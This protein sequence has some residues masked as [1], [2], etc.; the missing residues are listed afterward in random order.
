[1]KHDSNG[2]SIHKGVAPILLPEMSIADEKGSL[3]P[4]EKRQGQS[5]PRD[6]H[7]A[8]ESQTLVKNRDMTCGNR[9]E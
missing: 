7:T 3:A 1:V 5:P 9:S 4:G 6:P 8:K 2:T